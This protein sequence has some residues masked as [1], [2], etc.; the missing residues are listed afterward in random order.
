VIE[1]QPVD[2]V[3]DSAPGTTTATCTST[4]QSSPPGSF[5]DLMGLVEERAAILEFDGGHDRETADRMAREMVLGRDTPTP[6]V[7]PPDDIVVA[8]D[9]AGLAARATPYVHQTLDR[10]TGTVRVIGDRDDPFA[11]RRGRLAARRPGQCQCGHDDAW[12][13]VPIHGGQS[14]RIDCGHCDRFGWFA[15]WHGQR[16]PGP[17]IDDPPPR[18]PAKTPGPHRLSFVPVPPAAPVGM[19]LAPAC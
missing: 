2:V 14:V 10:F 13:R 1:S 11:G 8:V 12:K 19:V 6:P 9:H 4:V 16:L 3:A 5:D 18:V 7:D 17:A 15:V